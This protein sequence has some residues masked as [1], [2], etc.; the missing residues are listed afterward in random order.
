MSLPTSREETATPAS[1]IRS[2]LMNVIQDCIVGGKH[3]KIARWFP[4]LGR[5]ASEFNLTFTNGHVFANAPAAAFNYVP[6][7]LHAGD[8]IVGIR[9]N[10]KGTG[11]A[12]NVQ[13]F[14]VKWSASG[15]QSIAGTLTIVDPPNA[16]A[17]YELAIAPIEV[18]PG[19]AYWLAA[20]FALTNQALKA[21]GLDVQRT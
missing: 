5:A 16:W 4:P 20:E 13:V 9:A 8:E 2:H 7:P 12:G 19:E 11:A 17:I 10:V 15:A 6:A 21:L 3:G 1:P 14:L 18:Q